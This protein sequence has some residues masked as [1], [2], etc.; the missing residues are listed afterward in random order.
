[1]VRYFLSMLPRHPKAKSL[2]ESGLFHEVSRFA[3][4]ETRLRMLE[5]P[6]ERQAAFALFAEGVLTTRALHRAVEI[7]PTTPIPPDARRR[8]GLPETLPGADGLFRSLEGEIHAYQ[9]LFRMERDRPTPGESERFQP[10]SI[11]A[12][13]PLLF[14]NADHL[15]NGWKKIK[16]FHAIRGVDLDRLEPRAFQAIRRWMQGAGATVE[17]PAIA[18]AH[19]WAMERIQ[20]WMNSGEEA[21]LLLSPGSEAELLLLRTIQRLGGRRVIV[22]I[23]NHLEQ[24]IQV[25][26]LWRQQAGWGDLAALQVAEEPGGNTPAPQ[27]LDFPLIHHPDGVRRFLSWQHTGIRVILATRSSIPL[28]AS[29]MM[30]FPQADYRIAFG[31]GA[32]A[33]PAAKRLTLLPS[34]PRSRMLESERAATLPMPR[35]WRLLLVPLAA[36]AQSDPPWST[37][38]TLLPPLATLEEFRHLHAYLPESALRG[39]GESIPS[40]R[41]GFDWLL[42]PGGGKSTERDRLFTT[43]QRSRRAILIQ[44]PS[45]TGSWLPHGD[46]VL[47]LTPPGGPENLAAALEPLLAATHT[48]STGTLLLPLYVKEGQLADNE[49]LWSLL[50][51]LRSLDPTLHLRIRGAMEQLGREGR[52][53]PE[54]LQSHFRLLTFEESASLSIPDLEALVTAL[55]KR[56]GESWDE[57][58]GELQHFCQYHGHGAVPLLWPENPILAEW[59]TRQRV[60]WSRGTLESESW[61]RLEEIG[62]VWDLEAFAWDQAFKRLERFI[63]RYGHA[64]VPDPCPEDPALGEWTIR[65]R[66]LNKKGKLPPER[67]TRLDAIRFVWD[68]EETA[69]EEAFQQFLRFKRVRGDAKIPIHCPEDPLLGKWAERQRKEQEQKKLSPIRQARL[70]AEGFVWDLAAAA[71]DEMLEVLRKHRIEHGHGK[72][73]KEWPENPTLAIWAEEQRRLRDKGQL[74]ADRV[75]RLDGVDFVWDLKK[76]RWEEGWQAF[77]Q[78]FAQNGHGEVP[79]P[80]SDAPSLDQWAREMRRSWRLKQ[81]DATLQTRLEEAGFVWDLEQAAW[82]ARLSELER[83]AQQFG[84]T[85][86]SEPCETFPLLPAWVQAQRRAWIKGTLAPELKSRLDAAGFIWDP[87][88][89]LWNDLFAALSRFHDHQGHFNVPKEW[90][91]PPELHAWV[92]AQRLAREKEKLDA[93]KQARLTA[94]GFLWNAREAAWEEQWLALSRFRQSR[95]H[96]LVPAQWSHDPTLARWVEQQRRDYR[97]KLLKPDQIQRLEALGF[98]WDSRAIFWEEMFAALTEYREQHGDCL[99]SESQTDQSQLAWWVA[100]QRKARLANQLEPERVQRLDAIG[101]VWD[102]Q[103]VIWMES[104]RSMESYRQRFGHCL[105]PADWP[106]NPRLALWVTAQRNARQKG[107]LGDKRI[108]LLTGLGMIWDPKE[109]I[110]EEMILQLQAFQARHGHCEVPLE[111]PEFP[112]LGLWI[113]FQRQAKKDGT[114]DPQR[115]Q[116]LEEIGVLWR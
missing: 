63:A 100:A 46:L 36:S 28:L 115:L 64:K 53:D 22:V 65:Q 108:A 15:N 103:E 110:A 83:Y 55:L 42:C 27:E 72:V 47:F 79:D 7:W 114:L 74:S 5:D 12:L 11:H 67:I 34:P 89:K 23:L 81:L 94:L 8:L 102:A 76:A 39:A 16:N 78:F 14:T 113:Q 91:D 98:I 61:S 95:N 48:T 4:L 105:V 75:A 30:G 86:V 93:E 69:W 3:E 82:N 116:R 58:F 33:L 29:A 41:G 17:R 31:G 97:L 112:R 84:D 60:A 101:F 107:H 54:P 13:R 71:W 24:L 2:L 49:G 50:S 73:P 1:M 35:P 66:Q 87:A 20:S 68:P 70:D 106:E 77:L 62:F 92:K 104:F 88:E 21:T 32:E 37:L 38:E 90:N 51:D 96:C 57:R 19:A 43:F 26:R 6:E 85:G 80:C 56:L 10:L 99:V 52:F 18:P 59:A 25:V 109:A 9:L 45:R 44:T 40:E 111:S